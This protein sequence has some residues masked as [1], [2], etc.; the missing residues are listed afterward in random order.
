MR[1]LAPL[2]HRGFR[3]LAGGQVTSNVGDAFYA[4]ALP[5]YVLATHGGA[6]LLAA[7]LAAYGVPRTVLVAFGGHAS[8][9]WKPW[10]VMMV[11]DTVRALAVGGLA[12]VAL[13]GPAR[14]SLLVPV[15][16]VLGAGE[17]LFL[18][19][20]FA[21]VPTLLP[22]E[23]LEAG[24]GLASG[25]TQLATLVGPAL[26]GAVVAVVGAASAFGVDA[27]TFCVSAVTLFGVRAHQRRLGA[28]PTAPPPD[29]LAATAP[30][31]PPEAL[32][33]TAPSAPPEALAATASPAPPD[34]LAATALP[35]PPASP[36]LRGLL[37]S[38]RVLQVILIV[39]LAANLGSGGVSEVA[40]PALV[41][42]PF[43]AGATGY[44]ALIAAFGGGALA[45]TL[46]VGQM[47]R[48]RRPALVASFAFLAEAGCMAAVPYV[49]GA[50]VAAVPLVALGALNGFGNVVTV[51]AFQRWA[52]REL[53]GRLIGVIMIASIGIFP[54]SV[55]FGGAV[56]H[57][58]GPAAFFPLSAGILAMAVLGGLTQRSW[59]AFGASDGASSARDGGAE[60]RTL[61]EGER[62][63]AATRISPREVR[64]PRVP[65][66]T[67]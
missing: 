24:N 55:L 4:V 25:G 48:A 62:V 49:G 36:T 19:G 64:A 58:L 63:D 54:V 43:H 41:H 17:G 23:E 18:P 65:T 66:A 60:A 53:M 12:V 38:E 57:A 34:A 61:Q 29:A 10:T 31:A 8:D 40:L 6:L 52:P 7:V 59:R 44:G 28:T 2:R 37:T 9:R 22:D 35:A 11:A 51:T 56:V 46:L 33:A 27:V 50:L 45:G 14:A 16:I 15:A 47:R 5:W 13:L 26:G 67:V 21:I 20:S 32:A 42:G 39:T 1:G 3:L 30:S